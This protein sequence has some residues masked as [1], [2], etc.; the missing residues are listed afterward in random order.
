MESYL[1]LFE[2]A[3]VKQAELVGT[4]K[5]HRQAKKA[6]L[7]VSAEGHIVSCAGNPIIVLLRLITRPASISGA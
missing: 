5:A 6:G 1:I 4:P 2:Q 7:T 3:I